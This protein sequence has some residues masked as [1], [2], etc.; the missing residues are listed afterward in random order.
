MEN[1]D[2][3]TEAKTA[4]V[5]LWEIAEA[6]KYQPSN[7]SCLLRRELP[8]KE[9][10]KVRGI[11]ADISASKTVFKGHSDNRVSVNDARKQYV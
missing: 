8:E 1:I 5:K 4:G 7:F 2:I 6:L 11:I 3:R 10:R 9:K